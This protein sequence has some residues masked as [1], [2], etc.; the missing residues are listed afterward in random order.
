MPKVTVE[1]VT[2]EFGGIIN[3]IHGAEFGSD[4]L[5]EAMKDEEFLAQLLP[6]GEP[7]EV[8]WDTVEASQALTHFLLDSENVEANDRLFQ[9]LAERYCNGR[10]DVVSDAFRQVVYEAQGAV[11]TKEQLIATLRKKFSE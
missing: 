9:E 2:D 8:E 3:I 6:A 4:A 11:L 5:C 10:V 7:R 1:H